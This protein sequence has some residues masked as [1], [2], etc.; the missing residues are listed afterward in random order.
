MAVETERARRPERVP[1]TWRVPEG[2]QPRAVEILGIDSRKTLSPISGDVR[3][4]WL[5]QPVTSRA[6]L[7]VESEAATSVV[8]PRA[9]WIPAAWRAVIAKLDLHG[10]PYERVAEPRDAD[11]TMYRL[12]DPQYATPQFEGHVRVTA[13]ATPERRRERFPAGSVRVPTN[14]PLGTLAVLLLEPSSPDSLFQWGFL[15][16]ILSP[17]EYVEEYIMEPMAERMLAEDPKRAEEFREKVES[18]ADF[19]ADPRA[20]LRWFYQRTPFYDERARLYPIAREE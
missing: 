15:D 4:E 1:L 5:G 17:T 7:G 20:R 12:G 10:I 8:P 9:Y 16:S 13:T 18:D 11:V 6:P 14:Q 3:V 2:A 19:R